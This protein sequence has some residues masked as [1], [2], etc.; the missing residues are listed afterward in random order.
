MAFWAL[1]AIVPTLVA[2]ISVYGLVVDPADV[3]RQLDDYASNLPADARSLVQEQLERLAGGSGG[4]LGVSLVVSVGLALW[5]ASAG[6]RYL[7]SAVG[8][9]YDEP[10]DRGAVAMRKASLGVTAVAVLGAVTVLALLGALPPLVGD[11]PLRTAVVWLR[12][13]VLG[14]GMLVFLAL[15]YRVGPD[16]RDPA[17]RWVSPGSV[18]ALGLWLVASVAFTLYTAGFGRFSQTYGSLA[19]VVVLMLWLYLSTFAVL[20][21]AELNATLEQRAR[22]RP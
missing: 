6:V 10:D 16:R 1:F 15:V 7:L 20:L 8:A 18:A 19:G 3:A 22:R 14:A 21:G 5:S 13:P 2:V 4:A 17:W 11:G 12:W 9:A